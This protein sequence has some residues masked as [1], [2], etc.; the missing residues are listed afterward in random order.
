MNSTKRPLNRIAVA[1]FVCGVA[2]P[3]IFV[4]FVVVG[5]LQET[6][7]D[8]FLNSYRYESLARI[9]EFLLCV[10]AVAFGYRADFQ[11]RI[12]NGFYRGKSFATVG[13]GTGLLWGSV[14]L[15]FLCH[16]LFWVY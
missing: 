7:H 8:I 13:R 3:L 2:S 6:G 1:S 12:S 4:G 15:F 5:T 16:G 9:A 11:M 10:A 14:M